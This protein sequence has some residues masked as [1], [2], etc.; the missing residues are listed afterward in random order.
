MTTIAQVSA[1]YDTIIAELVKNYEAKISSLEQQLNG[2]TNPFE[3]HAKLEAV[4]NTNE[5]EQVKAELAATEAKRKAVWKKH[6]NLE[7]QISIIRDLHKNETA[8]KDAEIGK[9][10]AQIKQLEQR[11]TES[12]ESVNLLKSKAIE[13]ANLKLENT[14]VHKQLYARD[15][16]LKIAK[17]NNETFRNDLLQYFAQQC[18]SCESSTINMKIIMKA[19]TKSICAIFDT[20]DLVYRS[21]QV[22]CSRPNRIMHVSPDRNMVSVRNYITR[23]DGTIVHDFNCYGYLYINGKQEPCNI[24]TLKPINFTTEPG[25]YNLVASALNNERRDILLDGMRN[26]IVF[27]N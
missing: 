4:D 15:N 14:S 11:Q 17:A 19:T 7:K 24:N 9:L 21:Q 25:L 22:D 20:A 26:V 2:G 18:I 8:A 3:F 23:S 5:L 27:E 16:E 12:T 6:D 13:I 10:K 1:N